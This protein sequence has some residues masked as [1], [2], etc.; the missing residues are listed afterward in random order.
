ML[1]AVSRRRKTLVGLVLSMAGVALLVWR[2]RSV[3]VATLLD[4]LGQI[5]W[6]FL[7]IL[8][9]S[10]G[11]LTLRSLAWRALIGQ[12]VSPAGTLAATITG[13]AIG[14]VTPLSL[15]VSEPAKAVY[16]GRGIAPAHAFAALAAENF[17]YSVSVAIY[18][19]LG[20]AALL[21]EFEVPSQLQTIGVLALVG[22]AA[23]LVVAGWMA[24]QR[25]AVVSAVLSRLPVPGAAAV[26]ERVREFERRTYG[27]VGQQPGRVTTVVVLHVFFHLLS[28]LESWL[29]I[30]LL[31]GASNPLA[32]FVL[33]T[34]SRVITVVFRMIP[35]L[36]GVDQATSEAVA[37]AVG[38]PGTIGLAT[39]LV[40]FG[41]VGVWALV[42]FGLI[43]VNGRKR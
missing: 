39:S 17:L 18:I 41:R 36:A 28:F 2:V 5:R 21:T 29:T 12:P 22:M 43:A 35:M 33:D 40:R 42:G 37:I 6:G 38:L 19:I 24:W 32:A 16:L 30:W 26:V 13:D 25:P 11:R 1:L 7:A 34:A 20:T 8:A 10:L 31:T 14:N 3:G 23:I 15:L 9:V 4:H 27:S